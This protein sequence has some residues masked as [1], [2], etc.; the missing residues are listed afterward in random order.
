MIARACANGS[1]SASTWMSS[2]MWMNCKT[3]FAH[4]LAHDDERLQ[5][6]AAAREHVL[7][8]HTYAHRLARVEAL[9]EGGL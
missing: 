1:Q 3:R 9:L 4:Y 8:K 6:A 2:A 7:K 5:M